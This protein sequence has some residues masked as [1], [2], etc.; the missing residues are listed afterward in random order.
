[1]ITVVNGACCGAAPAVAVH[2][3]VTV[4]FSILPVDSSG[5]LAEALPEVRQYSAARS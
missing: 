1:L 4:Q 5:A 2:R 3:R